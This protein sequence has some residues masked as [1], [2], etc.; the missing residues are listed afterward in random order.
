M[1]FYKIN[2]NTTADWV[3]CGGGL[4]VSERKPT[5]CCSASHQMGRETGG[6]IFPA[7][8]MSSDQPLWRRTSSSSRKAFEAVL[9]L[10]LVYL[11]LFNFPMCFERLTHH[12]LRFSSSFLAVKLP[13]PLILINETSL[14]A[15]QGCQSA[16]LWQKHSVIQHLLTMHCAGQSWMWK[17]KVLADFFL[18]FFMSPWWVKV[19]S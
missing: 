14:L 19:C 6:A 16:M 18:L 4:S 12:A 8:F 10:I 2:N 1:T 11:W 5:W 15:E 9:F 3:A 13:P 7:C 17:S